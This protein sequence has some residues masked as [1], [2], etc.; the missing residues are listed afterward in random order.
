MNGHPR[1]V[2]EASLERVLSSAV[3]RRS[4][5]HRRFMRHVVQAALDGRSETLKEVLIGIELFDRQLDAYDPRLDPIVR[6]E[7]GRIRA[8]LTRYYLS[9][10]SG[11][12]YG[13][14]IP[15]GGYVP[16]FERRQLDQAQARRAIETYAVLPFATRS[17]VDADFAIGLADQIINL[18][19]RV[20]DVRVVARVSAVKARERDLDVPDIARL[21]KVTR[22][23]DGSFQRHGE[24]MRCVAH[25]YS[26][27]DAVQL[28]SQ[29]FDS[30]V[31]TA[32][33]DQPVDP[34]SFQDHVAE[35][36]VS[37]AL[38]TI[39]GALGPPPAARGDRPVR[40]SVAMERESRGLFDQAHY[41][42]RRFD[43]STCDKVIGL[44][45][46]ASRLD[47]E[48]AQGH[49]LLALAHFQKTILNLAPG[50][51]SAR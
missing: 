6:V 11:D 43:A 1:A 32:Q 37:A 18:L 38:P 19:G 8:K 34:F 14:D 41:L 50:R 29:S 3:F 30:N 39:D 15:S 33:T 7:A 20:R 4:D 24:R 22:V 13:F 25:I 47:P 26:G 42:F 36:I 51:D 5:R 31:L 16:R 40:V 48:N 2:V 17:G 28:W 12:P 10:G 9:E 27:R 44:A 23:I 35:A 46:K 21:L 45:E 49:V